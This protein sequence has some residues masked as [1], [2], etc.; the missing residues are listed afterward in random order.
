MVR[1]PV[2]QPVVMKVCL[3]SS[4][5]MRPRLRAALSMFK[6]PNGLYGTVS[7]VAAKDGNQ[8]TRLKNY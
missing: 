2:Q 8:P 3:S 6:C 1:S 4:G 5:A 7:G